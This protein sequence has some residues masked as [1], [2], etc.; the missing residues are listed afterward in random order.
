V[1]EQ[2]HPTPRR[3]GDAER[4]E[5]AGF[6]QEHMAQGRL[7]AAEFEERL[8]R[9]LQAKVQP[10]LNA[11]F[12]DLP[13][14]TP[15][16]DGQLVRAMTREL[17]EHQPGMSPRLRNT[18]DILVGAI[19]PITILICFIVGWQFWWLLFLPGSVTS[20]WQTR[21]HQDDAARKR[22]RR[23]HERELRDLQGG[24]GPG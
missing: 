6:L 16:T 15:R 1:T 3:I 14:P 4:D 21:K 18:V 11:L 20:M 24:D 9:A 13:A 2:S 23:E 5:A 10:E 7:D 8:E 17:T 19:W 22:W 12:T